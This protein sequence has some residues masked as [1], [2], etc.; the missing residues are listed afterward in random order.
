MQLYYNA[1]IIRTSLFN[2]TDRVRINNVYLVKFNY[3]S[4]ILKT[5]MISL[6]TQCLI[7]LYLYEKDDMYL[8]LKFLDTT[9]IKIKTSRE[10]S[11]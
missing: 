9:N 7:F 6:Y 1:I 5:L 11:R 8:A 10:K 4:S 2:L 3:S